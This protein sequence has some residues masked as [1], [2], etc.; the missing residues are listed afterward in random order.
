MLLHVRLPALRLPRYN[1]IAPQMTR[2]TSFGAT[3]RHQSYHACEVSIFAGTGS[4]LKL[5]AM[6]ARRHSFAL[7]S[8]DAATKTTAGFDGAWHT[9]MRSKVAPAAAPD[10]VMRDH[11]VPPLPDRNNP[12][13]LPAKISFGSEGLMDMSQVWS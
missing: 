13:M 4:A 9:S 11:D 6:V 10:S 7:P 12:D 2:L 8:T 1:S 5:P 3:A